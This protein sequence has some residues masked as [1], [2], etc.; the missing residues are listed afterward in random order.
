MLF[1][2]NEFKLHRL[3][4]EVKRVLRM[5]CLNFMRRSEVPSLKDINVEDRTKWIPLNETFPG[6]LASETIKTMLPHEKESFLS[7][8]RDWYKEAVRQVQSRIDIYDPILAT[9]QNIHQL[10]IIEG[11]ATL[12]A[13]ASLFPNLP[14]LC[15]ASL[16]TRSTMV[17]S[18]G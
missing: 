9:V 8:C 17:I 5:L 3:L 1:Q 16:K 15:K 12:D 7:S 11:A 18:T 6:I 4:P 10:A 13:A 2:A 14:T